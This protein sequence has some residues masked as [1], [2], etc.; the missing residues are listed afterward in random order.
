[1]SRSGRNSGSSHPLPCGTS[2]APTSGGCGTKMQYL[3][4]VVLA[5]A[6][7]EV[8][9]IHSAWPLNRIHCRSSQPL[10]QAD[11]APDALEAEFL[12]YGDHCRVRAARLDRG[13]SI[14]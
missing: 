7:S 8:S 14:I 5:T 4:R 3:S 6:V 1:M 10:H 12:V 13:V 11:L 9:L 2:R